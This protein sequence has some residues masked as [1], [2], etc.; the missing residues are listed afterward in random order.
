ME[1]RP[2]RRLRKVVDACTDAATT[3]Y[4]LKDG[5]D[6][7]K[8]VQSSLNRIIDQMNN[9]EAAFASDTTAVPLDLV[10][11]LDE[12]GCHPDF[13]FR[14]QLDRMKEGQRVE[15]MKAGALRAFHERLARELGTS[16][17][18]PVTSSFPCSDDDEVI[19]D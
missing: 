12:Q 15:Q 14:R 7:R 18:L 5:E 16:R 8:L 3:L 17:P 13:W 11:A 2:G 1:E 4:T 19:V 10:K 9:V 6:A